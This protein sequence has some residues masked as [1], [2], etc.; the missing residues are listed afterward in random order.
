MAMNET[1]RAKVELDGQNA[2]NQLKELRDRSRE[3]RKE[4]QE[5][6]IAKDPGYAAKKRE[7]DALDKSIKDAKKSTFDLNQVMKDLSGASMKQLT[8]A[9]RQLNAELRGMNRNT[10]EGKKAFAEKSQQLQKVQGEIKRTTAQMK[11]FSQQSGFMQKN[12]GALRMQYVAVAAAIYGIVRTTSQYIQAYR[13]QERAINKVGQAISSTSGAAGLSLR[14]LTEE[15]SNL[16]SQTIFGDEE[17]LNSVTAQLLTFTNV[18]GNNFKRAQ[19]AA[20][21]LATVLDGDLKSSSILLGKALNDPIQGLTAMRRVGIMFTEDQT[22]TIR[23]LAETNRL[24]E[25]QALILDELGRQYGNQAR[26]AALGSGAMQQAKNQMGDLTETIGKMLAGGI[27]PLYR[28]FGNVAQLLNK[29]LSESLKTTTEMFDDQFGKVADLESGIRP[30]LSRYDELVTKSNLSTLEQGELSR[31]ITEVT[32]A[33]PGAA[34]GFDSYGKA[35]SISTDRAREF[36]DTQTAMLQYA[37]KQAI[38]ETEKDIKK[39]DKA[40]EDI[41]VKMEQIANTGTFQVFR[42][43]FDQQTQEWLE[44]WRNASTKQ[45]EETIA[46]NQALLFE[47]S[48]MLARLEELNGNALQK[49]IE[50][51]EEE[52]KAAQELEEKRIEYRRKSQQELQKLAAQGDELAIETLEKFS[53]ANEVVR[54]TYVQLTRAI[55]EGREALAGFV[56]D[57]NLAAA[58]QQAAAIEVLESQKAVID[59]IIEAKGSWEG[60]M[61]KLRDQEFVRIMEQNKTSLDDFLDGLGDDIANDLADAIETASEANDKALENFKKVGGKK[62]SEEW[63]DTALAAAASVSNAT[64]EIYRNSVKAQTDEQ[65]AALNRRRDAELKN[66]NLTAEEKEK[67]NER[68]RKQEAKIKQEAFRKQKAA[69]IIQAI[70]N[71][72]LAITG[73]LPNIPLSVAAGIAGAAQVAVIAAQPVP[74]FFKGRYNVT[75]QDDGRRYSVPFTGPARTGIYE[76]P[77]LISEHGPELI[78]DAPTTKN[79]RLNYPEIIQAIH[80][81]RVPQY[82]SGKFPER[83]AG[84]VPMP[85]NTGSRGNEEAVNKLMKAAIIFEEASTKLRRDGVTGRWYLQDFDEINTSK[86]K[87]ENKSKI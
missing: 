14:E 52:R 77:A 51:R 65:I 56:A 78:I 10:A 41:S 4:L 8:S 30:L 38:Q 3:L 16:Q 36:I 21:D 53:S 24:A 28:L 76:R 79:I 29:S 27:M 68:Y 37:N 9:Q 40:I 87:V 64:I 62:M 7:F 86:N 11:G 33:M 2:E 22:K 35:I 73:A 84:A 74:Q 81:A 82:A 39:V 49:E 48:G 70:I 60:F 47:R 83:E 19:M 55:S 75:G 34:S 26:A 25:A 43:Y 46:T 15:A 61:T 85:L 23:S 44:G 69:D 32:K 12:L 18:A 63:Q 42:R 72:A 6:R 31:I 80:Q 58:E 17:I 54:S 66:E 67:I 59:K 5:M 50:R 13:E 71:T 1:A 20:M 45:V 57:G